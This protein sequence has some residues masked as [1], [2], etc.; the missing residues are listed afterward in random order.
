MAS[1]RQRMGRWQARVSR[2]GYPPETNTFDS[3]EDAVKWARA[4]E[5]E[6]DRGLY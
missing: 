1:I 5:T 6:M 4:L 3:R 2:K